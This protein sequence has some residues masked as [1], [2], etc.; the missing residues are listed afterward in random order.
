MQVDSDAGSQRAVDPTLL[1]G[2]F[3]ED[4]DYEYEY[5]ETETEVGAANGTVD[6]RS[7]GR[8]TYCHCRS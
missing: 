2:F 8:H 4:S 1:G 3:T 7:C 6:V 5:D